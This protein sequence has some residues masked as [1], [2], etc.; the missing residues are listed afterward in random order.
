MKEEQLG[1]FQMMISTKNQEL[2]DRITEVAR[3][4]GQVNDLEQTQM[5]LKE[6]VSSQVQMLNDARQ[7]SED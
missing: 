6:E 7:S 5:T 3:L 4:Q 1:E 2:T